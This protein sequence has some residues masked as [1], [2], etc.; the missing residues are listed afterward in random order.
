MIKSPEGFPSIY[1]SEGRIDDPE[2]AHDI[3]SIE[4]A[5]HHP[6]PISIS[7]KVTQEVK[8]HLPWEKKRIQEIYKNALARE[9]FHQDKLISQHENQQWF[10]TLQRVFENAIADNTLYNVKDGKAIDSLGPMRVESQVKSHGDYQIVISMEDKETQTN[11]IIYEIVFNNNRL[12]RPAKEDRPPWE[13]DVI[14]QDHRFDINNWSDIEQGRYEGPEQCEKILNNIAEAI[15]TFRV[16]VP[17]EERFKDLRNIDMLENLEDINQI[18]EWFKK[19]ETSLGSH[20]GFSKMERRVAHLAYFLARKDGKDLDIRSI[21][22]KFI[23]KDNEREY[24]IDDWTDEEIEAYGRDEYENL[25][26]TSHEFGYEFLSIRGDLQ[27]MNEHILDYGKNDPSDF[28]VRSE[29]EEVVMWRND[30]LHKA[31]K[32]WMGFLWTLKNQKNI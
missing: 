5:A 17:D 1:D 10:Q 28:E 20:H 21:T 32:K 15:A 4:N 18:V 24:D 9:N 8:K 3:A 16:H 26:D 13:R 31:L 30:N 19:E 27:L 22:E 23:Q 7:E 6:L 25:L 29:N 2:V 12:K 14:V 11:Q